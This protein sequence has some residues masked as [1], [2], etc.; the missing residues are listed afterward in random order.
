LRRRRSGQRE[1]RSRRSWEGEVFEGG[2]EV[3]E[4]RKK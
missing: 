1:R 4:G 3:T 2:E